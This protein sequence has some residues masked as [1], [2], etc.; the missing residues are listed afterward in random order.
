MASPETFL[1]ADQLAQVV[2]LKRRA[3]Q[4]HLAHL[5]AHGRIDEDKRTPITSGIGQP[6]L[7]G[8]QEWARSVVAPDPTCARCLIA[9]AG[10]GWD[11]QV[12]QEEL[13][14]IVGVS[15]RTIERHRPHL[16][17]AQL[18]NFRPVTVRAAGTSGLVT[19][20][21]PDRFTLMSGLPAARLEGQAF[22]EA[23][24]RAAGVVDRVRW[25]VSVTD[26]ERDNAIKSVSWFLR[27]GW[28]ED[29]LLK[30]LDS[31]EDRQAYRPGGYLSVLLRKLPVEYIV[32]AR[33]SYRGEYPERQQDCPVCD[34]PFK[35]RAPGK[36]LC[37]GAICLTPEK[38]V[39]P[40][41][42]TIHRIA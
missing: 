38:A 25:F 4:Y 11:G 13:A 39:I 21:H 9:L 40:P 14:K 29:A 8:A 3:T 19:G 30:A 42:T 26:T 6:L 27:A 35:T 1:T 22:D 37:G 5:Y 41:G 32:P 12:S 28:P 36:V 7:P 16:V 34:T 24:A 18:V 2:G 15:L 31:A 33:Q 20:R 10:I 23:P 17:L